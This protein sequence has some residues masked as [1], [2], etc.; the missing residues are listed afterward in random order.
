MREGAARRGAEVIAEA[1][2]SCAA[3][4]R[5]FAFAASGGSTP[6]RMFELLAAIGRAVGRRSTC[7]RSTSGSRRTATPTG[8]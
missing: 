5:R 4:G 2:R 6:W 1:A 7:S 8:R 3:A